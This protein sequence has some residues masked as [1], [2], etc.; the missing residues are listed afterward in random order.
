MS[1]KIH[2]IKASE[3]KSKKNEQIP[4]VIFAC[5]NELIAKEFSGQRAVVKQDDVVALIVRKGINQKDL[6]DN[7]WL[8]VEDAYRAA[9]WKV[10][11][12]K[13]AYCESYPAIF[14]FSL[15]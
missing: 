6:Y 4:D 12:D 3:I 2:P 5:F 14:I 11:Y 8:D 13:P 1:E 10:V 9:G 7:H 15:L